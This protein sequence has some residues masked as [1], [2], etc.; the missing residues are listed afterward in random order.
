MIFHNRLFHSSNQTL[1]MEARGEPTPD[2]VVS[3]GLATLP[4]QMPPA[5][6]GR[7]GGHAQRA[8]FLSINSAPARRP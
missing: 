2:V 5:F 7:M 6:R 4:V 3:G 8:E 1:C